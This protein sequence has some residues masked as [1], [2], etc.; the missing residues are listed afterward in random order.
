MHIL[1][2]HSRIPM[3]LNMPTLP[4]APGTF[5]EGFYC[6]TNGVVPTLPHRPLL[7]PAQG[8]VLDLFKH[9]L[10]RLETDHGLE[11]VGTALSLISVSR[12]GLSEVE[13]IEMLNAVD[14][15]EEQNSNFSRLCVD[16]P[17]QHSTICSPPPAEVL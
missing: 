9:I 1:H 16:F 17:P 11:L 15:Q 13:I 14:W 8:T 2:T 12:S 3:P 4:L 7:Q 5:L 10:A 6:A